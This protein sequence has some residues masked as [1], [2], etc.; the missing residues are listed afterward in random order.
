MDSAR[1][2]MGRLSTAM[3]EISSSGAE[4]G[5]I[6]KTI[7]EIAFQTNLLA[8]NAAV[9]AARAGEAGAGFAVVADEVRNLA[10]RSAEAARS[11]ADLIAH[12]IGSIEA[13]TAL[14]RSTEEQFEQMD[15]G[16]RKVGEL[17]AE[18]ANASQEQF[19][20]LAQIDQSVKQMDQITQS[21]TGAVDRSAQATRSLADQSASLREAVAEL[22]TMF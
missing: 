14:T 8:L 19:S 3:G 6:I 9:E 20:G 13:G 4:I 5:K 17:V 7:D 15:S 11:T 18:V 16:F 22:N 10:Q 12:T 1:G 2:S 21:N